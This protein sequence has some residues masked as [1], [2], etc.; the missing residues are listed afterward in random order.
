MM[1][2][3]SNFNEPLLSKEHKTYVILQNTICLR[4]RRNGA[5]TRTSIVATK[6]QLYTGIIEFYKNNMFLNIG[7]HPKIERNIYIPIVYD[8]F[9]K[10]VINI[11]ETTKNFTHRRPP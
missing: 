7:L 5:L 11:V 9:T 1:I 4:E 8:T 2:E 10:S 3:L 6:G